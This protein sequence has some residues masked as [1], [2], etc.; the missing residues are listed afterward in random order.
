MFIHDNYK[1]KYETVEVE[2]FD[3]HLTMLKDN[4]QFSD[5][6]DIA[7]KMGISSAQWPIFGVLWDS[8]KVLAHIM[9]TYNIKNKRILEL[10]CG[11]GLA[12]LVLNERDANITATDYHPEVGRFLK[13][14]SL[15]NSEHKIEYFQADWH[16]NKP[17]VR[18]LILL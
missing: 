14:N 8:S 3:I 7:K 12:S 2:N 17:V 6:Y 9:A 5:K 1:V 10:G 15:L 13:Y 16:N 18:S 11:L 4:Q